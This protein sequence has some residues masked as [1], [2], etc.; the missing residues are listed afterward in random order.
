MTFDPLPPSPSTATPPV[1]LA[2]DLGLRCGMAL[3]NDEGR[4]LSCRSLSLQ[5]RS[6]LKRA[7]F[8]LIPTTVTHLWCEGDAQLAQPWMKVV[9]K[10]GGQCHVVSAE[11]WRPH[12]LSSKEQADKR[13]AKDAARRHARALLT[14]DGVIGVTTQSDDVA[15]AILLGRY[16]VAELGWR[17]LRPLPC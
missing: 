8:Q 7:V 16:A 1:L 5:N 12:L 9:Q 2:V 3:F 15:E 6:A 4:L 10:R 13:T 11:T 14:E 17:P